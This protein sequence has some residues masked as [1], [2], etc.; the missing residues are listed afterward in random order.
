M[1]ALETGIEESTASTPPE[2]E[3]PFLRASIEAATARLAPGARAVFVLHDVEGYTHEEIAKTLGI[4]AGGSKSQLFK[5][6]AKLR[7]LLAH[8]VEPDSPR[9]A[10]APAPAS[11]PRGAGTGRTGTTGTTGIGG[12]IHAGIVV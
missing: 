2:D 4:T 8:L 10:P 5:A 11:T 6:R 1:Q 9:A 3:R 7:R 12:G